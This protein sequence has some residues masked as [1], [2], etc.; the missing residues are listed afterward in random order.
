MRSFVRRSRRRM[1]LSGWNP[2]VTALTGRTPTDLHVTE[3][4][5]PQRAS[6]KPLLITSCSCKHGVCREQHLSNFWTT[7]VRFL[8][9]HGQSSVW[10]SWNYWAW[11]RSP[12]CAW[13]LPCHPAQSTEC[14]VQLFLGYL[15]GLGLCLLPGKPLPISESHEEIPPDLTWTFSGGAWGHFLSSFQYALLCALVTSLNAWL[16]I[17][18]LLES[19]T[20]V[21]QPGCSYLSWQ[22]PAISDLHEVHQL[23][24]SLLCV[25]GW[26]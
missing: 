20:W 7:T 2:W 13:S 18:L 25:S 11:K 16:W 24:Q 5:S 19:F 12:S 21:L 3:T 14:H 23:L 1:E 17:K 22:Y 6:K 10:L 26:E 9:P 4:L 15:Q 8:Q